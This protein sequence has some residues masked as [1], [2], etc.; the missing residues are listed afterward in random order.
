MKL[1]EEVL[2]LGYLVEGLLIE[3]ADLLRDSD[4]DALERFNNKVRQVHKKRLTIETGCLSLIDNQRP[5]DGELRFL[6]AMI[7]IAAE[8]ERI[9]DHSRRVARANYL[10]A[11]HQLRKPLASLHRLAVEIQSLL[12]LALAAFARRDVR[13]A[14]TV[15]AGNR[16]IESLYQQIRRELLAVMKSNPH[17]ANQA[18]FMLRSAYNL[19]RATERVVGI[20]DWVV[21][22]IEGSL[23]AG[24]PT[25]EVQVHL[26]EETSIAL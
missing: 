18:I 8:L 20:C 17:I 1:Q 22:I 7:E 14:W 5:L 4:L 11:D 16:D 3:A 26:V 6:V 9:A 10:T 21:F 12:D 19:R 13:A 15:A 23:G 2:T 25:P 24:E